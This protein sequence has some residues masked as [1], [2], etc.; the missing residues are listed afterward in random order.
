[1]ILGCGNSTFGEDMQ[2]DGWSGEIVNVDY[3]SV[4]IEQMQRKYDDNFYE[5]NFS[6]AKRQPCPM[7]FMC[8]DVTKPLPFDDSSF[9]LIVCK[10]TLDAVLCSPGYKHNALDLIREVNRMLKGGH[11]IFFLVTNASPQ[12]RVEYLEHQNRLDYYWLNVNVHTL[13]I[14]SLG[15]NKYVSYRRD[16][17][18][19]FCEL[20]LVPNSVFCCF[21]YNRPKDY[22]YICRKRQLEDERLADL[23]TSAMP[24]TSKNEANLVEDQEN[25]IAV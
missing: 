13:P 4:V 7:K 17:I 19:L 8:L 24:I 2:R 14:A 21:I 12:N 10:A 18:A 1:L 9:D 16:C 25:R 11:G 23:A 3:S 5:T 22:I 20:L 6:K 15:A